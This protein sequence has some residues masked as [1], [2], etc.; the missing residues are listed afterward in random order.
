M[1]LAARLKEAAGKGGHQ[2]ASFSKIPGAVT[3]RAFQRPRKHSERGLMQVLQ[4]LIFFLIKVII[5][6]AP[7]SLPNF[8]MLV[9]R[10]A[11]QF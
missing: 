3:R 4:T 5:A 1:P 9:C 10:Y 11:D 2:L 7:L 8:S 6:Y